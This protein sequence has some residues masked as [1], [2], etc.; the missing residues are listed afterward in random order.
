MRL[1]L[2][3]RPNSISCADVHILLRNTCRVFQHSVNPARPKNDSADCTGKPCRGLLL[4]PKQ[5]PV[6]LERLKKGFAMPPLGG[7][8]SEGFYAAV[9]FLREG[10]QDQDRNSRLAAAEARR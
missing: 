2:L 4:L 6:G 8:Q 3:I 1:S 10:V 7:G 9:A 5:L